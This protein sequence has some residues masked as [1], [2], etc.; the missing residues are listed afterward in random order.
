[1]VKD[2]EGLIICDLIYP[3][4]PK[5]IVNLKHNPIYPYYKELESVSPSSI[6]V[7]T[8]NTEPKGFVGS[9][10]VEYFSSIKLSSDILEQ[11]RG[12]FDTSTESNNKRKGSNFQEGSN[13]KKRRGGGSS[14]KIMF[15]DGFYTMIA[16]H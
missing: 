7:D 8:S 14:S 15:V 2:Q 3:D 1:M 5:T 16:N 4:T 9:N 6:F 12:A 11:T 13:K 10:R